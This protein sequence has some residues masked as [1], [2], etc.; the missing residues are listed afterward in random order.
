MWSLDTNEI[1]VTME[2]AKEPVVEPVK[3]PGQESSIAK[4]IDLNVVLLQDV[5]TAFRTSMVRI[6]Q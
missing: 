4:P 5:P 6:V 1:N 3:E 2:P